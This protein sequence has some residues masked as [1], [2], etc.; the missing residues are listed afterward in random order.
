MAALD[1]IVRCSPLAPALSAQ[2]LPAGHHSEA[3]SLTVLGR[4]AVT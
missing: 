2:D 4:W 3:M 1:A